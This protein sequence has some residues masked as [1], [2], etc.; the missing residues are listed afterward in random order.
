MQTTS[1]KFN[2]QT[3]FVRSKIIFLSTKKLASLINWYNCLLD[4]VDV[5]LW[6]QWTNLHK[7]VSKRKKKSLQ[8]RHLSQLNETFND[9]VI[10][11]NTNAS[12][13]GNETL[14]PQA[15]GRYNNF[16]KIVAGE[17]SA[18]QNKVIENIRKAVNSA[19]MTVENRMHDAVFTAV[20]NIVIPR[21]E[22]EWLPWDQSPSHQDEDPTVCSKTLIKE[23]SQGILKALRS[24]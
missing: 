3:Q 10:G 14:E 7:M 2:C 16:D 18:W 20:N 13:M 5:R 11:N 24:C 6:Y 17:N 8:K 15:N 9:F 1:S 12:A 23:I 4:F 22:V 21:V 19:V